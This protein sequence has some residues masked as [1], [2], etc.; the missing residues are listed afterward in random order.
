MTHHFISLGWLLLIAA[1]VLPAVWSRRA[2]RRRAAARLVQAM[3]EAFG[4]GRR[5]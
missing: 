1:V 4:S 2:D 3:V 5:G